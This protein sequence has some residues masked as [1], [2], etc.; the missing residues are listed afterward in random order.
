MEYAILERKDNAVYI[1]CL[2]CHEKFWYSKE[3]VY[4][5]RHCGS[6]RGHCVKAAIDRIKEEYGVD[7]A[8]GFFS[9]MRGAK[10]RATNPRNKDYPRYKN[11]GWGF[12]DTLHYISS[13]L[14]DYVEASRRY[15][16]NNLTIDRTDNNRGYEPGNIRFVSIAENLKNRNCVKQIKSVDLF[17]GEEKVWRTSGECAKAFGVEPARIWEHCTRM[18][19]KPYRGRFLFSY[20]NMESQT[21]IESREASRVAVK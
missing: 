9:K 10:N 2:T 11:L 7:V 12:H 21:T 4:K 3:N 17:N 20:C 13:C 5:F 6:G 14:S 16:V 1:E 19:E 8:K 18:P 15:G